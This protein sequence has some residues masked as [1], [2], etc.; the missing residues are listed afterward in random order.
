MNNYLLFPS[1]KFKKDLK[2]FRNQP[3]KIQLINDCLELLANGGYENIPVNMRPHR[4]SGGYEGCWEC[5]IQ[6]DLLIIWKQVEE[7]I[8]II[9]LVR[10]GS[11]AELFK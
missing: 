3:K 11:H 5:H 8:F 4:L 1:T 2:K 7:S 10:L 6:P 9:S